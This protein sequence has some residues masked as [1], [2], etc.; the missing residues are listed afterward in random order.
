MYFGVRFF[1]AQ[2]PNASPHRAARHLAHHT[3]IAA[4]IRPEI[5]YSCS[6]RIHHFLFDLVF[7]FSVVDPINRDDRILN[8]AA[9]C[10]ETTVAT[11]VP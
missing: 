11:A 9:L 8:Q 1:P 2:C 5:I 7:V 3:V 6:D 4:L 10:I